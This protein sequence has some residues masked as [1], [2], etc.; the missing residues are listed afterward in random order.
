MVLKFPANTAPRKTRTASTAAPS[1]GPSTNTVNTVTMLASP[2]FTPGMGTG[3]DLGFEH[4]N[5]QGNGG[6]QRQKR[7]LFCFQSGTAFYIRYSRFPFS[8]VAAWTSSTEIPRISAR[9]SAMRYSFPGSLRFPR[10]GSG[11]M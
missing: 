3:E 2:S 5:G 4:E 7:Q 8:M 1:F 6:Q 11:D 9:R 10:K